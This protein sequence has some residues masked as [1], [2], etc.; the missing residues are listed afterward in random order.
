MLTLGEIKG[1]QP[2]PRKKRYDKDE[3]DEYLNLVYKNYDDLYERYLELKKKIKTLSDGVQ[4]Y[5]SIETTLQQ[6]LILAEKTAQETKDAA[7]LKAEAI[8]K[9]AAVKADE[10]LG[11]AEQEYINIKKE[12]VHLVKQFNQYK[13]QLKK[14]VNA[15]VELIDSDIFDIYSPELNTM[16]RD[17]ELRIADQEDNHHVDNHQ[18]PEDNL[19]EGNL[20]NPEDNLQG[21][22][23]PEDN[24]S[25]DIKLRESEA[26]ATIETVAYDMVKE[27]IPV[28]KAVTKKK[29]DIKSERSIG[30]KIKPVEAIVLEPVEGV[31][32]QP[33]DANV[34]DFEDTKPLEPIAVKEAVYE[35][36]DSKEPQTLNGLLKDLNIGNKSSSVKKDNSDDD[37]FDFLGPIE[38]EGF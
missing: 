10:I 27:E 8:E 21:G 23:L 9:E 19:H 32:A 13:M 24:L 15:Q 35:K 12:S 14:A 17:S 34:R 20:Q 30:E 22:Y 11:N 25:E 26:A 5:R 2:E 37:P 1:K 16:Y 3:M 7:I 28:T 29:E 38:G 4:Y 18:N 31:T 6:A 36:K 33:L